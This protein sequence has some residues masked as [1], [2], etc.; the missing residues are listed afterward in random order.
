MAYT[1]APRRRSLP[2]M[3]AAGAIELV[4]VWLVMRGLA[5]HFPLST[6]P[7]PQRLMM[8]SVHQPEPPARPPPPAEKAKGESAPRALKAKPAT[9]TPPPKI[10]LREPRPA[11]RTAASGTN[12]AAGA[13]ALPG[14]GTGAGGVGNG[15]GAGGAGAG[16]GA[17]SHAVR[18]AGSLGDRDYPRDAAAQGAAGSPSPFAC[19]ATAVSIGAR[20]LRRAALPGS[21]A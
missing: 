19:A 18:I 5:A 16:S 10:V 11:P 6:I 2:G 13:A 15:T 3:L 7:S 17:V 14:P 8:F 1:T 21:I 20:C 9:T 4:L 12:D